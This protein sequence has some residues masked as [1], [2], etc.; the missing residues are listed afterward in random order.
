MAVKVADFYLLR[1]ALF[2]RIRIIFIF[3]SPTGGNIKREKLN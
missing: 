3:I 2:G 1:V